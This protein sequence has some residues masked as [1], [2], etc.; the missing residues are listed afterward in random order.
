[1]AYAL[2]SSMHRHPGLNKLNTCVGAASRGPH[3][4]THAGHAGKTHRELFDDWV[5]SL[6][7]RSAPSLVAEER[8]PVAA[9]EMFDRMAADIGGCGG[10]PACPLTAAAYALGYNLA[11]EY[12]A[13][14]EKRWM[15][16]S[17]RDLHARYMAAQGVEPDWLF[18][19]VPP[20]F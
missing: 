12:L 9:R 18:L 17:F 15:L 13:D 4:R 10:E 11:I 14:Y 8:E 1:M 2:R 16:D 5:F 6:L 20:F 7:G 19:E 3:T